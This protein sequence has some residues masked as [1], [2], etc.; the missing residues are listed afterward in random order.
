MPEFKNNKTLK[1]NEAFFQ[2]LADK[3]GIPVE[4]LIAE[5]SSESGFDKNLVDRYYDKK[6]KR[7]VESSY[8]GLYQIGK[9]YWTPKKAE[10][11]SKFFWS[12]YK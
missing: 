9:D 7:W 3:T 8:K 12:R 11:I 2:Y 1:G 10:E 6:E 4:W 5:A